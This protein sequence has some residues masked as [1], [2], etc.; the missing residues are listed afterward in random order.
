MMS[1]TLARAMKRDPRLRELSSQ[2]HHALVLSRR[3]AKFAS[4]VAWCAKEAAL[5]G[6]EF[7]REIDPHFRVEEEIL[8]PGL[9]Q[10][11]L[12][13]LV[14]RTQA[15]HAFLRMTVAAARTGDLAAALAF[16]ERLRSHVRF[17]EGE[18][19]PTC[20]ATLPD[21]LLEEAARRSKA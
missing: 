11:N 1:A 5:L 8:L 3:V 19:F 9:R 16:A 10:A 6:D 14:E 13:S 18:L 12:L 15:D 7:D 20:E 4:S 2:H 17:E 21:A